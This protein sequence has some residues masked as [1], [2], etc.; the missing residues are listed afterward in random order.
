MVKRIVGFLLSGNTV[1][2]CL[3]REEHGRRAKQVVLIKLVSDP[4]GSL[5]LRRR[6][7]DIRRKTSM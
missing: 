2:D 7:L 4:S 3:E 1:R 5:W 6:W